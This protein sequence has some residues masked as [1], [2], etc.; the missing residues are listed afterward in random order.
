MMFS[1]RLRPSLDT[2]L[3]SKQNPRSLP[4]PKASLE[5]PGSIRSLSQTITYDSPQARESSP[6]VRFG[7]K[8][9]TGS[10]ND[11]IVRL[12]SA[13]PTGLYT[14]PRSVPQPHQSDSSGAGKGSG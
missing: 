7:H 2:V 4:Y 9:Q 11:G 1:A 14:G 5:M 8:N 6:I 12:V 13:D 3:G 10:R